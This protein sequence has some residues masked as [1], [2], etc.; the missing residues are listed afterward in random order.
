MILRHTTVLAARSA[1]ERQAVVASDGQAT[2]ETRIVKAEARKVH[3]IHGGQVLAGFAGGTADG[4]ALLERLEAKLNSYSSLRRAAVELSKEWRT[5]RALRRLEAVILTVSQEALLLITGQGD[6][7]E[8]DDGLAGV[9]SGG[10]YALA[11]LR[12]LRRHAQLPLAEAA[13]HALAIAAEI[14]VY[15]GGRIT[16]EEVSW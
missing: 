7:L 14:D 1:E 6:V 13:R 8:P 11:A 3:R 16:V 12:A 4:L 5:D 15:S 10:A 2:M 9:G